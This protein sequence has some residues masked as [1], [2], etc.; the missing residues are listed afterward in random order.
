MKLDE[1]FFKTQAEVKE[2]E[3]LKYAIFT[4]PYQ[5]LLKIVSTLY[6]ISMLNRISDD[7]TKFIWLKISS[8]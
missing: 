2:H 4:G 5:L 8:F 1:L 3:I 6:H 7:K